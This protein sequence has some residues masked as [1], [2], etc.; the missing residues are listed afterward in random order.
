MATEKVFLPV[1]IL[2]LLN[3]TAEGISEQIKYNQSTQY[4]LD[5]NSTNPVSIKDAID[6]VLDLLEG[7]ITK[8][9]RKFKI[10]IPVWKID[11]IE[12]D[13]GTF[14]VELSSIDKSLLRINADE[15]PFEYELK[16]AAN[17]IPLSEA[18][19][20]AEELSG[21]KILKWNFFK[22]KNVWE[23]N[24]WIFVK[25]GKAQVR[26]N[27]ESGELIASKKKK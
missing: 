25:S 27:A 11:L 16:P 26:V 12:K 24:F 3:Y 19:K 1:L 9:E 15:G 7:D 5:T 22:N 20:T 17:F 4:F 14:E 6:V 10:D 18:K 2:L 13:G 8:A 21:K 23:Y